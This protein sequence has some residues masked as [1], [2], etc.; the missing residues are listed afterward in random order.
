MKFLFESRWFLILTAMLRIVLGLS[1]DSEILADPLA[2]LDCHRR[3]YNLPVSQA[4][5][6]GRVCWDTVPVMSC[7]G[8]C[9]SNEVT[10][11]FSNKGG[12]MLK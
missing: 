5:S 6:Q 12:S 3:I 11:G 4:D 1:V 2:T 7:W 8:R 10:I 9:D